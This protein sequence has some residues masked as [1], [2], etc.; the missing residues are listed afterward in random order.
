MIVLTN[1]VAQTVTSGSSVTF[2]TV[3]EHAGCAECF[4][5]SNSSV[6]M[7]GRNGVYEISFSANIGGA[8]NSVATLSIALDGSPLNETTMI[9]TPATADI[10]NNVST[11]T[12]VKNCCSDFDRITV[13]NTGSTSV[14]IGANP[15]L[16]VKK[17]S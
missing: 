2:D 6:K 8:A 3:V 7:R 13:T 16:F 4:R 15:V 11:A 9:S 17:I 1:S 10:L 12:L 14:E 5:K